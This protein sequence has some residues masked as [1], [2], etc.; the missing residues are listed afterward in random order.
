MIYELEIEKLIKDPDFSKS[1]E[2]ANQ[3]EQLFIKAQDDLDSLR[4]RLIQ[5]IVVAFKA[6]WRPSREPTDT[7]MDANL[8]YDLFVFPDLPVMKE[9]MLSAIHNY[10]FAEINKLINKAMKDKFGGDLQFV[11]NSV[12]GELIRN[13]VELIKKIR[14]FGIVLDFSKLPVATEE[15]KQVASA[16]IKQ[17]EGKNERGS[18][19]VGNG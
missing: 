10:V 19:N 14:E 2:M 18:A 16:I 17:K 8:A 9:P 1:E 15:D 3:L 13:D 12:W 11:P 4:Q 7:M 6:G 5:I